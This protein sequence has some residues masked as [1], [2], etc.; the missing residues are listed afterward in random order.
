VSLIVLTRILFLPMAPIRLTAKL[1]LT[2]SMEKTA[3]LT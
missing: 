2:L 3:S 1:P